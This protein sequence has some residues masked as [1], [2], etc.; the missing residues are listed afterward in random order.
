MAER[1]PTASGQPRAASEGA[2]RRHLRNYLIDRRLQ[3][4]YI[5]AVLIVSAVIAGALGFMLH[6]QE[7]RATELVIQLADST[8]FVD[9]ALE[10]EIARTR[11]SGDQSQVFLM[12]GVGAGLAVVLCGFLL[13]T[14]HKV[15]GPLHKIS[16]YF[17]RMTEGKLPKVYNLRR[18]DELQ[19]FFERFKAM[20]EALRERA[21][22]EIAL[23]ERAIAA[24]ESSSDL[25]AEVSALR[26]RLD[27]KRA[28]L[29]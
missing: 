10:A 3:L 15:A 16:I 2:H 24:A 20:D 14:T 12:F 29:D 7:Q 4:R 1:A 5:I 13:I 27:A 11:R 9:P 21:L 22:V 25:G 18:G 6:R 17:D 8:D 23:Y 26:D 19:A 28:S